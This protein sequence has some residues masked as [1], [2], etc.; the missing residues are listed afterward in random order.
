MIL[1]LFTMAFA[2][3]SGKFT[4]NMVI[5]TILWVAIY[6]IAHATMKRHKKEYDHNYKLYEEL[7]RPDYMLDRL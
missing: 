2:F 1:D 3:Y 5:E 7:G 4:S 6:F